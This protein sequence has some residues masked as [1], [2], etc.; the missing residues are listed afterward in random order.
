MGELQAAI[1]L[2]SV[3]QKQYPEVD[4]LITNTSPTGAAQV[5]ERFAEQ[6]INVFLPFDLPWLMTVFL[7]KFNPRIAVV[8][9][10]EIWPNLFHACK[11]RDIPILIANARLSARSV[12]SYQRFKALFLPALNSVSAIACQ[13]SEDEQRFMDVGVDKARL[14]MPGNLKFDISVDEEMRS[15]AQQRREELGADRFIWVAASTRDGEELHVL[16]AFSKLRETCRNSLLVLVPRHPER[17]DDVA[18]IVD[19]SGFVLQRYTS[20]QQCDEQIDVF[21]LD[22]MGLLQPYYGASDVV[23]VGGSL[24]P[25]GGHNLLEP[26]AWSKPVLCGPHVFHCA[27]VHELLNANGGVET[28]VDAD[29]LGD[30]L[31]SLAVSPQKRRILGDRAGEVVTQNQGVSERLLDR[32]KSLV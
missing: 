6:V 2:I 24:E 18:R 12:K 32:I 28:V 7:K 25:F 26:A 9:E 3:L 5:K 29:A 16:Q 19:E 20:K 1:P 23:F 13:S 30:A 27:D 8:M 15:I 4:L 21:L 17:F 31:S 22:R 14:S 10:T 11:E